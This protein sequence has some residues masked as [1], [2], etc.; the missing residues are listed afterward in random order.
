MR[1]NHTGIWISGFICLLLSSTAGAY[2]IVTVENGGA[3]SGKISFNGTL[4]VNRALKPRKNTETCGTYITSDYYVGSSGG[5]QNV[6]VAIE[7]IERGKKFEKR[8]LVSMNNKKCM[9]SPHVATGIKNQK[10][11]LNN[12]DPVLHNTH[13]YYGPNKKTMYNVAMPL[14]NKLIKKPLRKEGIITLQCDAHD[15][16]LGYVYVASNPYVTVTMADGRFSITDVPPGSYRVKIW[17]EKLGEVTQKVTVRSGGTSILN[18]SFSKAVQKKI[19]LTA[20]TEKG[21]IQTQ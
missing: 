6:V 21:L 17:H 1:I 10:L 12:S 5:V 8:G 9:F 4:P 7:N 3:I 18:H 11:A 16:M 19:S 20:E 14:Q 2:Q 15:W 13:L